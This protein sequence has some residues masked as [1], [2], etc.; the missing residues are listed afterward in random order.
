MRL[1]LERGILQEKE[2]I[3]GGEENKYWVNGWM[4][5]SRRILEEEM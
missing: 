2:E 3:G 1:I 5:P 4:I